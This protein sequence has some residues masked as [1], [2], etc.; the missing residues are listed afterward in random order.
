MSGFSADWLALRE[1]YDHAARAITTLVGPPRPTE[2]KLVD[3]GCGS[4]SNLRYLAPRL[5]GVQYWRLLDNDPRLLAALRPR[6]RHW[7]TTLAARFAE[8]SPGRFEIET[9][10]FRVFATAQS[11]E[12]GRSAHGLALQ[13]GEYVTASALLDLVSAPWLER[14]IQTCVDGGHGLLWA[15]SYDGRITWTPSD[16]LDG[17]LHT[18]IDLHQR[19]DK[20]FGPALGPTAAHHALALLAPQAGTLV[21][22]RSDWVFGPQD[23]AVQRA[24]ID[25]WAA[26]ARQMAPAHDTDIG[27]WAR[28]RHAIVD[29]GRSQ[30]RVGHLDLAADFSR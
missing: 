11:I 8:P 17:F 12:L 1:P 15:L 28:R 27:E 3:L 2:R 22:K 30:L 24:L 18:R 16:P 19:G 20:G 13:P 21:S 7:A 14:L 23:Q 25:D 26:A 4:G 9:P 5:G 29:A 6:L 10:A